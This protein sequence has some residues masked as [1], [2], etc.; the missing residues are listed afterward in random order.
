MGDIHRPTI[1]CHFLLACLQAPPIP[2]PCQVDEEGVSGQQSAPLVGVLSGVRTPTREWAGTCKGGLMGLSQSVCD[3]PA[4]IT[5]VDPAP[6]E[7]L[8]RSPV[9]FALSAL[10]GQ[11]R[12]SLV[13]PNG[14]LTI[15]QQISS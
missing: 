5:L 2:T 1:N 4:G 15:S 3:V 6:F 11:S 8:P 7:P 9:V 14:G 12:P 10:R 13:Q